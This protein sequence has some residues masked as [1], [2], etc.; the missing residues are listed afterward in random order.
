MEKLQLGQP[1]VGLVPK[2]SVKVKKVCLSVPRGSEVQ[3][4]G[5]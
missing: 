1:W 4:W 3:V 2:R 5:F